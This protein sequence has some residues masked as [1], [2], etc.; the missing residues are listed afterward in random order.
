MHESL[1]YSSYL[2]R[3]M[4]VGMAS[5]PDRG[6]RLVSGVY[7][8]LSS[9]LVHWS[10]RKLLM[11]ATPRQRFRC[12]DPKPI[13]YPSL[14][15]PASPSRTF[16]TTGSRPYLYYTRFNY[17]GCKLGPDRDLVRVPVEVSR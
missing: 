5:V 16:S 14:L 2:H 1:T 3:F 9:D 11:R 7:F 12:G 10:P 6:G 15:D 13:A 17:A 8:S 4:L